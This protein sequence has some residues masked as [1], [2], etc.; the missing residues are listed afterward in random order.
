MATSPPSSA[1]AGIVSASPVSRHFCSAGPGRGRFR[2]KG[3]ARRRDGLCLLGVH[4]RDTREGT[5]ARVF[6]DGT[7]HRPGAEADAEAGLRPGR[8]CRALA[9]L[10]LTD[11]VRTAPPAQSSRAWRAQS[12]SPTR[13]NDH[14]P[15]AR[16]SWRCPSR[17]GDRDGVPLPEEPLPHGSPAGHREWNR[18]HRRLPTLDQ[19]PGVLNGAVEPRRVTSRQRD[20]D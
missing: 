20:S 2:L 8:S 19:L 13:R 17:P 11:H 1:T 3:R 5:E 12:S 18:L 6:C 16:S 14:V 15:H 7:D 10:E 4:T 9:V